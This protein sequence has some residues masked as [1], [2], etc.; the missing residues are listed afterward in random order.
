M[1]A[2]NCRTHFVAKHFVDPRGI[3]GWLAG[4]IMAR[5]ASNRRRN[6]WTL[7]LL[8]IAPH[9]RVLE[10]GCGPGWALNLACKLAREGRVVGVDRS[11]TMLAQARYRNR[12]A[13]RDGLLQLVEAAAEHLPEDLGG[14]FD[15][16]YSSNVFGFL[17]DPASVFRTLRTRLKPGAL[18]ATTWMPRLGPKTDEAVQGVA[19]SIEGHC[20]TV[21]FTVRNREFMRDGPTL[22]CCV[23]AEVP[24]EAAKT[25]A[26]KNDAEDE[27]ASR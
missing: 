9:H 4:Q 11:S 5:R 25:A 27:S 22:A 17:D 24:V 15:R 20:E 13:V 26:V 6:R 14:P 3:L 12:T 2:R 8:D 23:I 10:I 18:L 7:E 1:D 16:A 19:E 21:G